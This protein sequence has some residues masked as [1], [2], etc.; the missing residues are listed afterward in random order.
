M[1]DWLE[2]RDVDYNHEA[3]MEQDGGL[4]GLPDEVE[5]VVILNSVA[6]DE[7]SQEDLAEWLEQNSTLLAEGD[8]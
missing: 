7:L 1:T 8:I 4:Q 6:A 3:L 2:R 5:A